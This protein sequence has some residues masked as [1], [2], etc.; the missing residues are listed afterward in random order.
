MVF[1][2]YCS[3]PAS[4]TGL[5]FSARAEFR[6]YGLLAVVLLLLIRQYPVNLAFQNFVLRRIHRRCLRL[7][8]LQSLQMLYLFYRTHRLQV[9]RQPGP[10]WVFSSPQNWFQELLNN[11]ALDHWWKENFQVS[12][13]TFGFI[14][15][16]VGPA[17]A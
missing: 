1:T 15:G 6:P 17:I 3:S 7:R 16:V 11:R 2:L 12:R 10:A 8:F 4:Q 5:G 13:A 9:A 14:C